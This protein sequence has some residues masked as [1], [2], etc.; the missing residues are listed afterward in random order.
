MQSTKQSCVQQGSAADVPLFADLETNGLKDDLTSIW[1][2]T[3]KDG[4]EFYHYGPD[5]IDLAVNHL[6]GQWVCFHNGINF[7]LVVLKR[8][9]PWFKPAKIDDTFV[10]SC[11]FEPDR[12]GHGLADWGTQFGIPKPVHE[13]WT[14]YSPEMKHRNI[15]DVRITEKVYHHLL[16]ERQSWDWEPAIRLEYK[17]ADLHAKQESNGVG[18][19]MDAALKLHSKITAEVAEIDE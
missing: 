19:D 2:C 16:K 11:L 17:I 6:H 10:L 7:D 13:D 8:F 15:E 14:Q 3:I 9:Y 1:C 18:F 12:F 5:Q 4:D